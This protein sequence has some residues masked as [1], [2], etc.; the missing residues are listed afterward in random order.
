MDPLEIRNNFF[1]SR[2]SK[3]SSSTVNPSGWVWVTWNVGDIPTAGTLSDS[4]YIKV[5]NVS[6]LQKLYV[7]NDL[8]I[9]SCWRVTF[10]DIPCSGNIWSFQ[11]EYRYWFI[12]RSATS[13]SKDIQTTVLHLDFNERFQVQWCVPPGLTFNN[14][15]FCPHS[16]FMCFVWI[17][18]QT[19]IIS[20][21]SINWLVFITKTECVYCAVRTGFTCFI[22]I[23]PSKPSGHYMYRQFNTQQFYVL[24][25]QCIYV[26]CVDL[27]TNSDYSPIQH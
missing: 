18:E 19:A 16:V 4:E 7:W 26:F 23:N 6:F 22:Y 5:H 15:T 11:S 1:F 9:M 17:W 21:Y 24:P 25:T 27:R 2:E 12:G 8:W 20:L 10:E 13:V 3:N 14:S